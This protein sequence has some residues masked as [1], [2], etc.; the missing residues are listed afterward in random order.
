MSEKI[1][2]TIENV[3]S[4]RYAEEHQMHGGMPYT[5]HGGMWDAQK[6]C[7]QLEGRIS[8]QAI[9]WEKADELWAKIY[10]DDL[11]KALSAKCSEDD[12]GLRDEILTLWATQRADQGH[13]K[14][15]QAVIDG[16]F[17]TR[18]KKDAEEHARII[19]MGA[20]LADTVGIEYRCTISPYNLQAAMDRNPMGFFMAWPMVQKAVKVARGRYRDGSGCGYLQMV[21]GTCLTLA[22]HTDDGDPEHK[23]YDMLLYDEL[24]ITMISQCTIE[25]APAGPGMSEIT[26]ESKQRFGNMLS[27]AS[28]Y[29]KGEIKCHQCKSFFP[30]EG[31]PRAWGSTYCPKC[32]E[33]GQREKWAEE[34][35]D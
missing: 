27:D 35:K 31:R 25:M 24:G 34:Y 1:T 19:E 7:E 6:T 33:D 18:S 17:A 2:A 13:K 30:K 29:C 3:I 12:L 26:E 4:G 16:Y 9:S 5:M 23:L 14:M 8:R 20:Q 32:W 21:D 11:A 22:I 15:V 10:H 28:L